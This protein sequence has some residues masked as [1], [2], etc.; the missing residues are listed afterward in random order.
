[1]NDNFQQLYLQACDSLPRGQDDFFHQLWI[2]KRLK[3]ESP[4]GKTD[5][6]D[7]SSAKLFCAA[8][9]HKQPLLL[10]LPDHAPRRMPLLF[11]TG[12]VM[13]TLDNL[14]KSHDH[15][16]VY[17]GTGASIKDYLSLTYIRNE[18]LSEIFKQTYLGRSAKSPNSI[19]DNLP[20]TIFS[21]SPTD[22]ENIVELYHPKWVFIDC[23]DGDNIGWITPLIQ[24]LAEKKIPCIACVSNPLSCLTELFERNGWNIFSW[25]LTPTTNS[26]KS[27]K[28]TPIIVKSQI[29]FTQAERLQKASHILFECSKQSTH[30]LQIDA[31]RAVGR[32]INGLE[33]LL[34]PLPF[35]EAESRNYWGIYSIQALRLT[36]ERFIEA[37]ELDNIG[38]KLQKVMDEAN[39]VHEQ[40][41]DNK[42]PFWLALEELCIDPPSPKIPT[43]LVFQNRAYKQLFSLAMLAENNIAE[44]ELQKLNVWLINLKQFVQWHLQLERFERS[45][46][47]TEDVPSELNNSYPYWNPILVG[48]PTKHNYTRYAHLLQFDQ[49]C[50]LLLPH[51]EYLADWHYRQWITCL[52]KVI[53]Q[54]L[55]TL[56]RLNPLS[57]IASPTSEDTNEINRI[58]VAPGSD[59]LIDDKAEPAHVRLSKLLQVAPRVEEL[60]YL[61]DELNP[62]GD[63]NSIA[64][65]D[66]EGIADSVI[67]TESAFV[68]KALVVRFQ[69]GYEVTFNFIDK[70]QLV[71]TMPR[72][73]DLQERSVRSL[74]HGDVVLFINGQHRQSLYDLIISRVHDHPTFALHISLIERWQDE[75]VSCYKNARL[76]LSDVLSQM[77]A[78]GSQLQTE[79]AIRFWLWGQVMCPSDSKDLQRISD[80]LHMPF[81][82]QYY[83]QID[84]AARRLR[85]IHISLARKLNAWLEQEA[86]SSGKQSFNDVIDAE[87]GLEFKDFQEALMILTVELIR[88]ENGLFLTSDFGRVRSLK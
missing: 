59:I 77:Q 6:V 30:R 74:K 19:S 5:F 66:M 41:S 87:L 16:V 83:P 24:N 12:L 75:L 1:M 81:V 71:V 44:I 67:G 72:G 2:E 57:N 9:T 14:G 45:G 69:E 58:I 31:W 46:V 23:S 29:A 53:P 76:P 11:V 62:E 8:L 86:F 40:F 33:N 47:D 65:S 3:F 70:I 79:A 52:D 39:Y 85:G 26:P 38:V 43:I 7:Y 50:N 27:T 48:T 15:R 36:A 60:A 17:F 13:Y 64:D 21:Y 63:S 56:R 51:Q 25:S 82:Q 10:V 78:K 35:F 4:D 34:T 20:C 37:L 42:P 80:I 84:K 28:I 18:K 49:V 61:I 88:E 32:F 55:N 22:P 73:K 68:E 54:N